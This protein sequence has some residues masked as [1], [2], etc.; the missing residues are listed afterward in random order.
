VTVPTILPRRADA[1]RIQKVVERR[2][3]R[4]QESGSKSPFQ[5]GDGPLGFEGF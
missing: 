2:L 1:R 3:L 4:S 5:K